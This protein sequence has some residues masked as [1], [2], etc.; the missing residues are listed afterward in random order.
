[1]ESTSLSKGKQQNGAKNVK[2]K[3]L[4]SIKTNYTA[5]FFDCTSLWMANVGPGT[6]LSFCFLSPDHSYG[7]Q[8][9]K[10]QKKHCL[11]SNNDLQKPTTV[12]LILMLKTRFC[13]KCYSRRKTLELFRT[14]LTLT[15]RICSFLNERSIK[16]Y[17]TLVES[18][19]HLNVESNQAITLAWDHLNSLIVHN[20]FDFSFTKL[21]SR[22]H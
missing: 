19:F 7:Q 15:Q 9:N 14:K 21:I 5:H 2:K 12:C 8:E 18:T 10:Q 4:A 1:M 16:P 6:V 13:P 3:T 17:V 22:S 20:C 11:S